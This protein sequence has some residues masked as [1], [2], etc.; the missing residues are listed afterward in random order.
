[1]GEFGLNKLLFHL[2]LKNETLTKYKKT[3]MI[4][5]SLFKWIRSVMTY[6]DI[7]YFYDK[8]ASYLCLLIVLIFTLAPIK[9]TEKYK[10]SSIYP[11]LIGFGISL[12]GIV[13]KG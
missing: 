3:S 13:Y 11:A 10:S 5:S 8:T 7:I 6:N 9:T 2:L 1:M 4:S 12:H